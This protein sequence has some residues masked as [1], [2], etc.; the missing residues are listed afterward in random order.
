VLLN[1][2]VVPGRRHGR[3]LC[4]V[5]GPAIDPDG[6]NVVGMVPTASGNGYWVFDELGD[7]YAYGDAANYP[8]AADPAPISAAAAVRAALRPS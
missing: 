1:E 8:S 3:G 6:P 2:L 5:V 7:V 4:E